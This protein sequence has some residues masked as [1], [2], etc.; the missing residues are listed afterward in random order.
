MGCLLRIHQWLPVCTPPPKTSK[1]N[2]LFT[3]QSPLQM[4]SLFCPHWLSFFLS[5]IPY[6]FLIADFCRACLP[7]TCRRDILKVHP[8]LT[9]LWEILVS[10]CSLIHVP[11]SPFRLCDLVGLSLLTGQVSSSILLSV[12]QSKA[13]TFVSLTVL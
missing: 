11:L 8:L 4:P 5:V 6:A 7:S 13:Q 3:F 2:F 9:L 1:N 12:K 10:C